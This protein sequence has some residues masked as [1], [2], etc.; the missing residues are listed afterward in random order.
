MS[1]PFCSNTIAANPLTCGRKQSNITAQSIESQKHLIQAVKSDLEERLVEINAKFEEAFRD[2]VMLSRTETSEMQLLKEDKLST[3]R[4]LEICTGLADHVNQIQVTSSKAPG[5]SSAVEGGES[6]RLTSYGLRGCADTLYDTAARLEQ[7]MQ[8]IVDRMIDQSASSGTS[9][10]RRK[11]LSRLREDWRTAHQCRKICYQADK[12]LADNISMIDNYATG[13]AIQFMISTNGKTLHGKNR[14]L[15]RIARQIG[16]HLSD[17]SLQKLSHDILHAQIGSERSG[18]SPRDTSPAPDDLEA[19]SGEPDS[20]FG[21]Q[22]G[23]GFSLM[24]PKNA[25]RDA[26]DGQY[27]S[28]EAHSTNVQSEIRHAECSQQVR[29]VGC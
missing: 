25:A 24:N 16:G 7:R 27:I 11:Y 9:E 29:K 28:R 10:E 26:A 3:E 12:H 21:G 1:D 8:D 18:P 19:T 13:D 4:C 2:T 23:P 22:Y 17:E 15:G 5:S 14:G 20:R 6:E